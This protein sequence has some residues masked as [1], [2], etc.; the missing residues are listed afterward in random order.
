MNELKKIPDAELEVMLALW[1][2]VEPKPRSWV[3]QQLKNRCWSP[4]TVN[5]YLTRLTEKGMLTSQKEGNANYYFPAVS[6]QEYQ[7]FENRSF[8]QKL[9]GNSVKGFIVAMCADQELEDKDIDELQQMLEN[10]KGEKRE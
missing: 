2:A 6:R 10:L 9:Y 7:K 4:L 5:T 3:E 8:L 1:S